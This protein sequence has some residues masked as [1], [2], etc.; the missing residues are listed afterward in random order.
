MLRIATAEYFA[1]LDQFLKYLPVGK[2]D[3][4]LILKGHL[5]I[6]R[7]L[8]RFHSQNLPRADR[9]ASARLSFAQKLWIASATRSDPSDDWLWK[10]IDALNKLRNELAHQ[11]PMTRYE[12]LRAAF[13][14][15]V[16]SSPEM[17]ELE[18]PPD[19]HERLHRALFSVH[20]AMSHRVDL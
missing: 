12:V 17:P 13:L 9:L 14:A 6:E 16:E 2:D 20:E 5:L 4:V 19:I 18:P 11:L 3:E 15:V 10:A 7:L 8:E 1:S